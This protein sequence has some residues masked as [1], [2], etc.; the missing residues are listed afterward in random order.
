MSW[1]HQ[2]CSNCCGTA[3]QD[4]KRRIYFFLF[5]ISVYCILEQIIHMIMIVAALIGRCNNRS[6][7]RSVVFYRGVVIVVFTHTNN[8]C[9]SASDTG[10]KYMDIFVCRINFWN[11][12]CVG[13]RVSIFDSRTDIFVKAS[14]C[15]R[16]KM[17]R[18]EGDSNRQHSSSYQM[19]YGW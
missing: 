6:C 19:F 7:Y 1:R 4:V 15:L 16:Q 3:G 5:W 10:L 9:R 12:N 2:G 11:T 18:P 17:L 8:D 13:A 14:K